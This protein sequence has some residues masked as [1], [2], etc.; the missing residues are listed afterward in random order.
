MEI[1]ELHETGRKFLEQYKKE[2]GKRIYPAESRKYI[3]NAVVDY[4][5]RCSNGHIVS[6]TFPRMVQIILDELP[7]EDPGI[8][9][10]PKDNNHAAAGL[11]YTRY[12]Y[13]L[14]K[15]YNSRAQKNSAVVAAPAAAKVPADHLWI[16]LPESE[17][18]KCSGEMNG[19]FRFV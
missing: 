11:L 9:Y 10:I 1:C 4:F 12:K 19:L 2:N 6:Q 18:L 13:L 15:D 17:Q 16:D 7:D 5:Y 8:W 3:K 14:Q